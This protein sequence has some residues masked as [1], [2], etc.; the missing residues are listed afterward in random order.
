VYYFFS[1]NKF[2]E[3]EFTLS[4]SLP[5]ENKFGKSLSNIFTSLSICLFVCLFRC[6]CFCVSVCLHATAHEW[7]PERSVWELC[8]ILHHVHPGS[9]RSRGSAAKPLPTEPPQAHPSSSFIL[10]HLSINISWTRKWSL[11][12]IE[13]C[14]VPKFNINRYKWA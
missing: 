10:L 4:P 6:G 14:K 5:Q 9:L 12:R 7:K 13:W 2:K 1:I 3:K 8:L 11:Q